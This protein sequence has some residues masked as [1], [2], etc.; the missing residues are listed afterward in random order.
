MR[1]GRRWRL[2]KAVQQMNKLPYDGES[3]YASCEVFRMGS[4]GL[5]AQVLLSETK[6]NVVEVV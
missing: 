4:R 6:M 3:H 5:G 2:E 1:G